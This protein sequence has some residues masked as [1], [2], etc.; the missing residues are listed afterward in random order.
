MLSVWHGAWPGAQGRGCRREAKTDKRVDR[1]NI[2]VSDVKLGQLN[3]KGYKKWIRRKLTMCFMLPATSSMTSSRRP[4]LIHELHL[5]S[6]T[7]TSRPL[8]SHQ[9]MLLTPFGSPIPS[10]SSPSLKRSP[11]ENEKEI[12]VESSPKRQ[13][14]SGRPVSPSGYARKRGSAPVALPSHRRQP[15]TTASDQ[16]YPRPASPSHFSRAPTSSST[17]RTQAPTTDPTPSTP[18]LGNNDDS[19]APP[20]PTQLSPLAVHVPM[21]RS[22]SLPILTLSELEALREKEADLGIVRNEGWAWVSGGFEETTRVGSYD[23]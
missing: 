17:L 13:L 3:W 5:Q 12:D 7:T 21:T 23:R 20:V 16:H 10:I 2:Q 1:E 8:S 9:L 22:L 15:S 11:Q 19:R 4:S 18:I 6:S 14:K